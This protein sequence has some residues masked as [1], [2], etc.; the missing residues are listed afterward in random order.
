MAKII[1][2]GSIAVSFEEAGQGDPVVLLHGQGGHGDA[3]DRQIAAL[4]CEYHVVA[5]DLRGHGETTVTPRPYAMSTLAED[6]AGVIN[7]L[8][9]EA[10]H[11]VGHSL[12][13]MVALQLA[14]DARDLV[15]SLILVNS[16]AFGDG[17]RV[18]S[19]VV[20]MF[21]KLFG[22]RA[23]A[24]ANNK[25]HFPEPEQGALRDRMLAVMGACSPVGYAASQDAVDAFDVRARLGEIGC[26]VLVVHSDQ[27]IIPLADKQAIAEG[28]QRGRLVTVARSRHVVL[29]DQPDALNG[30][31]LEFL[32]GS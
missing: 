2:V 27:D 7:G 3:W 8:G 32:A 29:W 22:M 28:V 9:L 20:R 26:P 24:K 11:V 4:S 17:S 5:P 12:G 31:L 18:R 15:R 30:L 23:F 13:G 21:I 6:V 25:L 19:F 16:T 14:L 1:K 10:C